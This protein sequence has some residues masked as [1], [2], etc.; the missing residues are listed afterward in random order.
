MRSFISS[1]LFTAL[2]LAGA[3]VHAQEPRADAA[4]VEEVLVTGEQPGPGLWMATKDGKTLW[5]LGMHAPL[6]QKMTWRS[7]EVETII[8]ESQRVVRWVNIETDVEASF[9]AKLSALPALMTMNNN[10]DGAK[11]ADVVPAQTYE[12]W[13]VLKAK[14]MKRE[15]SGEKLRPA[16]AAL[17]LRDAA[18]KTVGLSSSKPEAVVWPAV[19]RLAKKHKVKILEPELRMSIKVEKPR[20]VIKQ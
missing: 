1:V 6:P 10:P 2:A 14:Y 3:R 15:K 4:P 19:E 13:R 8:A 17:Q 9:F 12:Q 16:F 5:I 18:L 20:E 11:L 7:R